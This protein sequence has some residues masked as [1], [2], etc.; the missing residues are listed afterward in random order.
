[1]ADFQ[2]IVNKKQEDLLPEEKTEL[3]KNVRS[4]SKAQ[5]QKFVEVL[6]QSDPNMGE[7]VIQSEVKTT[8][9]E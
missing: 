8:E 6:S 4:L 3:R 1:M 9:N 2:T 7:D 5:A